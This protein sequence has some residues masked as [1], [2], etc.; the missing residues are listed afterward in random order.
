M[1]QKV[2]LEKKIQI[3]RSIGLAYDLTRSF[4]FIKENKAGA[5]LK[6]Q[7][8]TTDNII[9]PNMEPLLMLDTYDMEDKL[10][11]LVRISTL[12]W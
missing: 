9:N 1:R 3:P 10:S 12:Y 7:R 5:A 8:Q 6:K 11:H 4:N 2:D